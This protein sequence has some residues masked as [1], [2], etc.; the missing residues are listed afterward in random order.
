MA[1]PSR[2]QGS[3]RRTSSGSASTRTAASSP[4]RCKD[5]VMSSLSGGTPVH[6]LCDESNGWMPDLD[7]I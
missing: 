6:Y 4:E 2:T 7:D 1:A 5:T 3:Y